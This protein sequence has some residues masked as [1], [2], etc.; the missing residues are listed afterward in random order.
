MPKAAFIFCTCFTLLAGL[1]ASA[2]DQLD[3]KV[4]QYLVKYCYEC[5][6]KSNHDFRI[7]QLSP[8]VGFENTP[9]WAEILGRITAGE[10]PP[11]KHPVQPDPKLSTMVTQWLSDQLKSGEA[12]RM[13]A[14]GKVSF[15][16]L[17]RDEYVNTVR[18]LL[19]VQFDATDPGGFLDDPEWHGFERIGSVLTLSPANIEKYL[20]AAE[21][22]LDE[23]F[24]DTEAPL[25]TGSKRA[26]LETQINSRHRET[27]RE[28]GLLD[29]VRFEAWPGDQF[30]YS[31]L[32]GPLPAAGM[33][34][35][36][37]TL[38]GLKPPH[39]RAPRLKVYEEKLDRVLFERDI[40]APENQPITV[41]FQAHLPKGRPS[42]MVYN[43]VPGPSNLPRSGR[44]GTVP[45]ISIKE[46]RLPWQ[47]KLTDEQGQARYPFLIID[48]ISW[49]GPLVTEETRTKRASYM[50]KD[51]QEVKLCL[52]R[53]ATDAFRKPITSD[54]LQRYV[55]IAEHEISNGESVRQ[56][57][58]TAMLAILC[59]KDFLF[60]AEGDE[61]K[62]RGE[63][64]DW[65]IASRLSYFLWSTMPDA[66]LLEL[67]RQGKLRDPQVR[68]EQFQRLIRNPKA[69]RFLDSFATQWLRLK[70]VGK[71]PPDKRLYPEYDA[72][73]EACMVGETKA[74]FSELVLQN[75]P[76]S[77]L[78]QSDWTM[79]NV[80]L[81]E[82]Y[83]LPTDGLP[84]DEFQRVTL[85]AN[86]QRGGILTQAAILSLTSD[87]T[88]HRPVHRGVWISENLLGKSPPPPP[89]NV[90]PI[91][92]N[93]VT[94][95]KATIR[96]K[97]AA[98]IHDSRCASCHANIDP[99]G[100]ALEN[101]DAIGRWR[102]E[103]I[104]EGQGPNPTVDASGTMPDGRKFQNVADFKKLLLED[105]DQLNNTFVEKL[106]IYA[107]RRT[108]TF[109][110]R[111][112]L[113]AI[114]TKTKQQKYRTQDA[115]RAL[116]TSDLFLKR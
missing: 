9:Q 74:F 75:R 31:A 82:Y 95:K 54:Q 99:Y 93:P 24:P 15:H 33:Y 10:M 46:G 61:A 4:S 56:A 104:T 66:E 35:I 67:A 106:A 41:T 27:L 47:M 37:Y 94:E 60:L 79:L 43:D 17:S 111:V 86:S 45:F 16:R 108:M 63:L 30:R 23:A 38:S 92:P 98:H 6:S 62:Q 2:A 40:I 102:T 48:S 84:R 113:T 76:L 13:A 72:H 89:A 5:H 34:E 50:P 116:I 96:Q 69:K 103:E 68:A 20:A 90:D 51:K 1:P 42:I 18:D 73:L 14:R 44:H 65:E 26:I 64:N 100:F 110:D 28:R 39:G 36:S 105:I 53:F 88:R 87:G 77:D 83:G 70:N 91:E 7:D 97:L 8:K 57:T 78:I 32:Q 55:S 80:R 114:A 49:K 12:A 107:T 85:A 58:K 3:A 112:F 11:K 21:T 115:V 52:Q 22:I 29:K 81:A 19:G 109:D 71:F 59:S 25:F 101:F